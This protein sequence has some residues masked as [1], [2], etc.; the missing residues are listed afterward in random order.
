[1]DF[2][3]QVRLQNLRQGLGT[4]MLSAAIAAE[5]RDHAAVEQYNQ[6]LYALLEDA[7]TIARPDL[8]AR[9]GAHSTQRRAS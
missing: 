7:L 6:R 1:M 4:L 9:H 2:D 3:D 5:E 8:R